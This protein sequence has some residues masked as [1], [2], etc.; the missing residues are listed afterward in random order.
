MV[1]SGTAPP[2][3]TI[4]PT[5]TTTTSTATSPGNTTVPTQP[6]TEIPYGRL[7]TGCTVSGTVAVTFDDGPYQWTSAL[8]DSLNAA[9]V[10]ATFFMVGKL[11][12]C[13]YDYASVVQKAHNS[14]HQIASHTWEH[15]DLTSLST[16][17]QQSQMTRL[18]T[19][20]KKILGIKPKWV[21]PPMGAQNSQVLSNLGNMGYKI[22]TWNFDSQDWN[23]A[24]V[25]SSQQRFNALGNDPKIIP[26]EHDALQSTAQQLGPWLITWAKQRNLKMVTLSECLGE[27]I[28][29]GQYTNVGGATPRDSSWVC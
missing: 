19:A 6:G 5:T 4:Q 3:T 27:P 25:S 13:I 1:L 16:A 2:T 26:L 22:V 15:K 12:G 14:G 7:V 23:G 21:R 10:K 28:P 24:S 20:F 11:Y 29:G 8:I 9:N 17:D 18:E